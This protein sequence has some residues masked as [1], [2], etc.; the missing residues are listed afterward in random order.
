MTQST[1]TAGLSVQMKTYYDRTLLVR[2]LPLLVHAQFG[3]TRPLSKRNGKTIEFRRF[4]SLAANVTPLTEGATP[5]GGNLTSS[6]ITATV[7]QYGDFIEG[8]DLLDLT[9]IDPILTETA[10]LLGEQAGL[11]TDQVVREIL[12]AGTTVQYANGRTSRGTITTGDN[13]TV[14]EVRK[15]VRTLKNNKART[16]PDGTYVAIVA[17]NTTYTLQSD[18][19]WREAAKYAGSTQ[20]FNGEIGQIYGVRF[21]ETTEAKV[22]AAEGADPDGTGALGPID[23][24]STLVL[25]ADAYGIIPLEGQ[26]LEFIFKPVGSAGSADPLNQRWTSGWKLAFTAKILN[27][28]FM[29]R[30]EHAVAN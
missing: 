13:L 29:L 14:T 2:A 8:S 28:L 3:Q 15:A 26:N 1:N 9:A 30:I 19:E 25:G 18:P 23:V 20:L 10:Q 27:D 7:N 22:F 5:A 17:P 4:A 16:L 11:S 6:A 21:V 12:H 24:Y